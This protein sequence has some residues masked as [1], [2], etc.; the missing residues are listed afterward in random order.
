MAT[1]LI[2]SGKTA[3]QSVAKV[4]K[5]ATPAT[6]NST[7][8]PVKLVPGTV[9]DGNKMLVMTMGL[10]TYYTIDDRLYE[11]STSDFIR[12]EWLAAYQRGVASAAPWVAVAK[13][14]M[15]LVCG[16]FVPWY[17]LL[18]MSCAKVGIFYA[19]NKES[20]DKAI[21]LTP[22]VVNDLRALKR[23]FP[24]LFK[25]I[26]NKIIHEIWLELRQGHGVTAEDVAFFV[27]RVIRGAGMAPEVSLGL[28]LKIVIQVGLLVTATHA[29]GM[30]VHAAESA[31]HRTEEE[32]K[33]FL[34]SMGYSIT[35][36]EAKDIM[37]EARGHVADADLKALETDLKALLP[38]LEDLSQAAEWL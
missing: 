24:T 30:V 23:K 34:A 15:A 19:S 33:E 25:M 11:C 38:S 22:K 6:F 10:T 14:E 1:K 16:I 8:G 13:A 20:M 31:A 26:E 7:F 32:L 2:S 5:A 29:P 3:M 21:K 4:M 28:V 9:W 12:A 36:A 27:G 35:A 17:V 18:G 37:K